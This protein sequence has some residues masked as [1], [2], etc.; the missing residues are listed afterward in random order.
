MEEETQQGNKKGREA[1]ASWQK[2]ITKNI[3]SHD[4]DFIHTIRYY[5]ADDFVHLNDEL[6]SFGE[7]VPT[8]LEPLVAENHAACNLPR[9]ERYNGIGEH[10]DRIVHHPCYTQAGDIIYGTQLLKKISTPG[11]LLE[12]FSISFLAS[13]AGEAGHNCPIACSAGILRILNKIPDFPNKTYY[14]EK[15]LSPSYQTNFTGA[16]FLT[17]IQGGSDVGLNATYAKKDEQ[18]NWRIYGEKWFCSNANADLIFTTARYDQNISGTKGLGLFL[19]PAIWNESHNLYTLRRLKDKLGTRSLA[20]AEL[21][22]HGAFAI[23]MGELSQG[24]SLT[25]ENVLHLSRLMNSLT[26]LAM[27]R[28]AYTIARSYAQHRIAFSHTIID[29]PLVKENLARIKAENSAMLAGIFATAKIQDDLDL[30]NNDANNKLLI[31]LLVNCQKYLSAKWSVE[32]IHH[33]LDVLAG[34]GTIETFSSIPRLLSD[35]IVC[36]NWEGTHNTLHMQIL[37]DIHKFN[38][39]NFYFTYMRD[40]LNKINDFPNETKL[41]A[42]ELELLEQQIST[43]KKI[44]ITLQSLQIRIITDKMAILFC[45]LQ[46]LFEALNQIKTEK[47]TSKMNCFHYFCLSHFNNKTISYDEKYLNLITNIV[48]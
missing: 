11:K 7:Q 16:Q 36:E 21:D 43:F 5:F 19:V 32:H 47:I 33:C 44:D 46:L 38:I 6:T 29:Y 27:T 28:R 40:M 26:V 8:Q 31:R 24:F 12:G 18:N 23:P 30:G 4:K 20:T 45:A 41:I 35:C 37:R 2:D 1:L 13:Q 3:Y 25:M 15:L 22:Y 42:T 10:F 34:N 17:E 48:S 39:D 14:M 9:L